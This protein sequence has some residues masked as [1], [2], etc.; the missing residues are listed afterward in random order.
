MSLEGA[1]EID[2]TL[3]RALGRRTGASNE[4]QAEAGITRMIE[5]LWAP[6]H[7]DQQRRRP[8][9]RPLVGFEFAKW[10]KLLSIH[11]DGAFLTRRP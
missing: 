10:K 1:S 4:E 5:T 11:L 6:R 9:L 7:A 8:D 3:Q 2:P